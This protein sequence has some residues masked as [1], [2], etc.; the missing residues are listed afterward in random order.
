MFDW[1]L[2]TPL[3]CLKKDKNCEKPVRELFL[4]TLQQRLEIISKRFQR[5]TLPR[6]DFFHSRNPEAAIR[7]ALL[8]KLFLTISQY[9][10]EN[11]CVG[12]SF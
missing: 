3:T 9:L 12:V 6:N 5:K 2:D 1:V 4:E 10:Q 8:R 11:T 7:S